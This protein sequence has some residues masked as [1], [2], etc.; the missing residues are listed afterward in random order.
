MYSM[1][2]SIDIYLFKSIN[3][4]GTVVWRC[5]LLLFHNT[6]LL[7]DFDDILLLSTT[8]QYYCIVLY[9]VDL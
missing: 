8:C 6:S 7:I 4:P 5:V 9:L 2:Y 1:F 3:I